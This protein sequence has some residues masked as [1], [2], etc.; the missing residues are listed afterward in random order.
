MS[1]LSKIND[2]LNLVLR[3]LTIIAFAIMVVVTFMQ[4]IYRFILLRPI[5]WAEESA[6]YLFVWISF[7]EAAVAVRSKS[8]VGV[9]LVV[10]RLPKNTKKAV[11]ILASIICIIFCILMFYNGIIMVQRTMNQR[12]A[13]MSMPMA[14]AY[15]AIPMGFLV[16][17][18][19]FI[20][21]IIQMLS[22]TE[23]KVDELEELLS[24]E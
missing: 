2:T 23:D 14:Y 18:I 3:W 19:N 20:Q 24:K 10:D 15:A 22:D 11:L 12:S 7:L 17:V 9:E 6:R 8:H 5:P 4:I 16:M 1:T 21:I 13:A